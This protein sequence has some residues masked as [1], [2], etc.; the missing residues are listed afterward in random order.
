MSSGTYTAWTLYRRLLL[1]AR[2]YWP[3]ILLLALVNLLATPIAL[4][5][6]VPLKIAVDSII[7][8]ARLPALYGAVLPESVRTTTGVLVVTAAL[9]VLIGLLEQLQAFG[10]WLLETYTGER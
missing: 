5:A 1:E 8:N 3:H 9:M 6:P 4:F 2:P 7:G 10:G